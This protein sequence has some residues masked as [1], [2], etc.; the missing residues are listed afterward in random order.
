MPMEQN[1][2]RPRPVSKK[3]LI[4][5][6]LALVFI[7]L[8]ATISGLPFSRIKVNVVNSGTTSTYVNMYV[9]GV[10]DGQESFNLNAGDT[11][12][13]TMIVHPG[14]YQISLS[15][16]YYDTDYGYHYGNT[17]DSCTVAYFQTEEVTI[18]I[19]P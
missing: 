11:H 6:V 2:V 9:Y 5:I 1:Q 15:Y 14:T 10:S 16:S 3:M 19:Y 17:Y 4:V 8:P 18:H 12:S 13:V 7:L